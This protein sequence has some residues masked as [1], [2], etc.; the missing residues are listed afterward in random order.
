ML[1]KS[2]ITAVFIL[3]LFPL[4]GFAQL[5]LDFSP[6][7][8]RFPREIVGIKQVNTEDTEVSDGF[9]IDAESSS[10]E[11][12][13]QAAALNLGFLYYSQSKRNVVYSGFG[14]PSVNISNSENYTI[15]RDDLPENLYKEEGY[16]GIPIWLGQGRLNL[17]YGQLTLSDREEISE[18]DVVRYID[19]EYYLTPDEPST[20]LV[21]WYYADLFGGIYN[22]PVLGYLNET[23]EIISVQLAIPVKWSVGVAFLNGWVLGIGQQ[24]EGEAYRLTEEDPWQNAIMSFTGLKSIASIGYHFASGWYIKLE[25]GTLTQQKVSFYEDSISVSAVEVSEETYLTDDPPLLEI[26]LDDTSFY[27]VTLAWAF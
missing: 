13:D 16:L 21:G 22:V 6:K 5:I 11:Y 4:E 8:S 26:S 19:A 12:Q 17:Y 9:Q 15:S 18:E 2:L 7:A 14:E 23:N 3:F 20:W 24:I 1:Y 27:G 25:G 10:L